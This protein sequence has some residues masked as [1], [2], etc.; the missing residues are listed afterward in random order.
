MQEAKDLRAQITLNQ[1]KVLSLENELKTVQA[2][3]RG[4]A[5]QGGADQLK[6]E[7]LDMQKEVREIAADLDDLQ[8][9]DQTNS[10][11]LKESHNYIT[12]LEQQKREVVQKNQDLQVRLGD[13]NARMNYETERELELEAL[14][15]NCADLEATIRATT[16]EPFLRKAD[17]HADIQTR[18]MDKRVRLRDQAKQARVVK[19]QE[20]QE[21]ADLRE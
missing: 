19:E 10:T 16:A 18:I 3:S 21:V 11:I 15:R 20:E 5:G 7:I 6:L 1:K 13:L 12:E 14:Q 2:N 9:K 4:P 17:G 8:A